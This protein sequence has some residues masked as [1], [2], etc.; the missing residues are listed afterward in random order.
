VEVAGNP[1]MT[2]FGAAFLG[3]LALGEFQRP[4]DIRSLWTLGHR[5]EPRMSEDQ[6]QFRL[7]QWHRAVERC[8]NW[9]TP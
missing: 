9:E 8:K 3:A 2:G 7:H 4:E 5:Y 6:R 1:E